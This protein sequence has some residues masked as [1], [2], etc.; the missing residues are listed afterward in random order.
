MSLVLNGAIARGDFHREVSISLTD[1]D[2][3]AVT[4]INGS[5]KSTI[6]HTI[7]GLLALRNGTIC[8][9]EKIWDSSSDD[10]F[11]EAEHRSCAVVFQNLRLFPHMDV[12]SNVAF[13]LRAHGVKKQEAHAQSLQALSQVGLHNCEVRSPQQLSGGEQQRV[14]LARALVLKPQVLLLDEPFTAIDANSRAALRT[15][16]PEVLASFPGVTV[17]VSHDPTDVESMAN[18]HLELK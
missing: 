13:G 2:V 15:L 8:C 16:M 7:A 17:L 12:I 4:G 14:A 18:S 10:V 6:L 9:D 5:G 11:V 1:G 3:L